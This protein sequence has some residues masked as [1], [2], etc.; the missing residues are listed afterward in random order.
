MVQGNQRA[1]SFVRYR[2]IDR[3]GTAQAMLG[4]ERE[5]VERTHLV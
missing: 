2:R 4:S 1:S 3:I 5:G